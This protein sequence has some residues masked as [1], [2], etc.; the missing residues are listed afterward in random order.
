M[1]IVKGKVKATKTPTR[2]MYEM[3]ETRRQR[4]ED[5]RQWCFHETDRYLIYIAF[6]GGACSCWID[7]LIALSC[8]LYKEC[9]LPVCCAT[10]S[11]RGILMTFESCLVPDSQARTGT[12]EYYF[13]CSAD[14]EQDW[15]PYHVDPYSAI[16]DDKT[17]NIHTYL[18][19]AR[20]IMH[21]TLKLHYKTPVITRTGLFV[22]FF[23][24]KL[25]IRCQHVNTPHSKYFYIKLVTPLQSCVL[26]SCTHYPFDS[27]NK[28]TTSTVH[29]MYDPTELYTTSFNR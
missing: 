16:C 28:A 22:L 11:S 25:F 24:S 14:H 26:C 12:G 20:K 3:V 15:Q 1:H 19:P 13:S 8:I 5:D 21:L 9:P 2:C 6:T 4:E 10:A 23:T 18:S 29:S 27:K 7:S 17:Y